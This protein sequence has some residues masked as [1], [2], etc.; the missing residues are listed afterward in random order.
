[1]EKILHKELCYK[2]YGLCFEVHRELNRF[3]REKQ[4]ADRFEMKL[5][6]SKIEYVREFN[7][8]VLNPNAP[9]GNIVDFYIDNKIFFDAK[10][11][12]FITKED[13]YQMQRYLRAA[14]LEL[15]LIV[16][17]RSTYLKPKRVLNT[18]LYNQKEK[19]K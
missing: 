8:S 1:M 16:N 19:F 12:R 11:K 14:N 7:I 17:F 2:I 15:G 9:K 6:D 13:Y 10:A 5:R 18:V 4:F 3:C